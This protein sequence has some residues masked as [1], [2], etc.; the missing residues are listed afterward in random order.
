MAESTQG[1]EQSYSEPSF[2]RK[3]AGVLTSAGADV[4]E[5]ALL[6]FY[7]LKRPETPLWA[8]TAI[9]G[10]LGYFISPLD[11]IPDTVPILG[12]TDDLGVLVAA[13]G[14]VAP[15]VDDE[16]KRLAQRHLKGWGLS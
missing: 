10:A 15:Y 12:F 2:W 16:V 14:S 6:L 5:N 13:V 7:A 9:L 11:V 3:C 4:I 8:R 1:Y